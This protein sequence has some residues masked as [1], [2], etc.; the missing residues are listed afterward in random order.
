MI[1]ISIAR[2]ST[3]FRYAKLPVLGNVQNSFVAL[4]GERFGEG[5]LIKYSVNSNNR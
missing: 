3:G 1:S 4:A 2:S 5:L